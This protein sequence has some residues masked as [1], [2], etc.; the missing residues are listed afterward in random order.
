MRAL[1]PL[2]ALYIEHAQLKRKHS[3]AER[4]DSDGGYNNTTSSFHDDPIE[5]LDKADDVT[6]VPEEV[7]ITFRATR[8][9][10]YLDGH[11]GYQ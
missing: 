8:N 4:T 11:D 10:G 1:H 2:P 9:T 6:D 3:T 7:E 5:V